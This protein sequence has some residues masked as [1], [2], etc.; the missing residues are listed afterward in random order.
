M[1]LAFLAAGGISYGRWFRLILPLFGVFTLIAAVATMLAV[2][3]HY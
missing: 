2:L 3:L 1:L